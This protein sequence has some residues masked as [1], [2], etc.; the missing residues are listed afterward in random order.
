MYSTIQHRNF[1]VH[2][3]ILEASGVP[4]ADAGFMPGLLFGLKRG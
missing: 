3:S 4:V 2:S 1:A